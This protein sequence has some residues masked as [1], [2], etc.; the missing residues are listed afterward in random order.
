[1]KLGILSDLHLG[2]SKYRKVRN[3]QNIYCSINN[4]S[5]K[6]AMLI[7]KNKNV[8]AILIAGDIFDSPNPD[9]QSILLANEILSNIGMPVYIIGG[10]HDYSQRNFAN[11][12]HSFDLLFGN[13]LIKSVFE[14]LVL[15]LGDCLLTMIPHKQNTP[16]TYQKIYNGN[17]DNQKKTS[18]LMFHGVVDLNS[19]N[20]YNDNS[21]DKNVLSN[22]HLVIAGDVHLPNMI[23]TK[24]ST[25][26]VPGS[27]MPSQLFI[28]DSRPSA[29][30]YNT[31]SKR[32]EKIGLETP[33]I[34]FNIFSDDLNKTLKEI[35]SNCREN[36]LYF[37]KYKNGIKDI[38]ETLYKKALK[39]SLNLSIQSENEVSVEAIK[40]VTD[41]WSFI[42][43]EYP[44]YFDEFKSITVSQ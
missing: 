31:N 1:M 12:Y 22:Y 41:F 38:D 8:D 21:V 30:I 42:K 36:D 34:V 23:K 18:I 11:G 29:Y 26:L 39:N 24:S 25:I 5:F 27:L 4:E 6:E 10:N 17:L 37:I 43:D 40:K 28:T 20:C 3:D 16:E 13:N 32:I 7:L 33:P 15:D 14:P 35:G 2:E 9:V 44:E 19:E